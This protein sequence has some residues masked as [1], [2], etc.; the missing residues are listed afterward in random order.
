MGQFGI[1]LYIHPSIY[2]RQPTEQ[3]AVVFK[4]K[5]VCLLVNVPDD[6]AA[7]A[8]EDDDDDNDVLLCVALL[9]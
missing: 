7:A 1:H 3:P 5:T 4:V 6:V 9:L 8:D 2:S